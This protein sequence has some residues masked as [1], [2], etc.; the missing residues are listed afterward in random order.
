MIT[1]VEVDRNVL[2]VDLDHLVGPCLR[3]P[4]QILVGSRLGGCSFN[5]GMGD[6]DVQVR[7]LD[8]RFALQGFTLF[9]CTKFQILSA[10]L[11]C[12]MHIQ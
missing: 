6:E 12:T 10:L 2:V 11:N 5:G 8:G 4:G 1:A 7:K 9:Y 3:I